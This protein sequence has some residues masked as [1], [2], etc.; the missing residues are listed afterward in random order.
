[1]I[2]FPQNRAPAE[3]YVNQFAVPPVTVLRWAIDPFPI[4]VGGN[5]QSRDDWE[6]LRR[7][8]GMMF[9]LDVEAGRANDDRVYDYAYKKVEL[10]DNGT[11]FSRDAIREACLFAR[12]SLCPYRGKLYV[13]C[14][15]GGS[16][17][18]AIAYAILRAVYGLSHESGLV[19]LNRAFP[20]GEGYHY[21]YHPTHQAY[22]GAIDAFID[23]GGID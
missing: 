16:R 5:V 11:P 21:G 22:I 2:Q 9:C 14:H 15:M 23:M 20:H 12:E 3:A 19:T 13:H 1:M 17:S 7:V 4:M 6:H 18:P 10:V 8:H